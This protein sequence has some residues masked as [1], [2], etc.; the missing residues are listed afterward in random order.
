MY[1]LPFLAG[2]QGPSSVAD[3]IVRI[4]DF[5]RGIISRFYGL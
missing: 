5:L 1:R 4:T 3:G 2:A